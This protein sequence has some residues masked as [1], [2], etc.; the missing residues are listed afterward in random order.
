MGYW[1]ALFNILS[2]SIAITIMM[3]VAIGILTA[4]IIILTISIFHS[5]FGDT[6]LYYIFTPLA[7]FFIFTYGFYISIKIIKRIE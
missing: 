2:S 5:I 1:K 7:S 4:F 3:T 6:I